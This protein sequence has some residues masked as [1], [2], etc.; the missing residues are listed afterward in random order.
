M[1]QA[2]VL[3]WGTHVGRVV[4][5]D[6]DV[7][8]VFQYTDEIRTF[9]IE[10]SPLTMPLREAPYR[11]PGLAADTF[12]RLPGLLADSLPDRF[13]NAVIDAWLRGQ[14]R[15]PGAF[16]AVERLCYTGTRGMG[17][18]EF[19]PAQGPASAGT[20][21]DLDIDALVSL[22]AS[23]L[24][25]REE[26]TATLDGKQRTDA[27]HD[28]L[29]VGTSAGGAR[30]KAIIA[31]NPDT[32]QV[33]SGQ[34]DAGGGFSYWLLKFDGVDGS[35]DRGLTDPKGFGLIE[36]AYHLMAVDAGVAMTECRLFH[37]GGR[38]H[39]MTRRFDRVASRKLHMQS[40]GGIA[41]LDYN[42]PTA[43]SYEEAFSVIGRLGLGAD[44]MEEQFRRMVFNVLARNQDDHVKNI[45]FLMDRD[46]AWSLSPAFDLTY[47]YDP[48]NRWM[49]RHQMSINGRRDDFTLAD[50][51]ATGRVARLTRGR[52]DAILSQV[53]DAVGRW[54]E[55]ATAAGVPEKRAAVV[56]AGHRPRPST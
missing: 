15:E 27:F 34:I 19:R 30:A 51:R 39:F 37:E 23:V 50:L 55:H 54:P 26:L 53:N 9:G 13:G 31:Y 18:L 6:D 28:I 14:G 40:L 41:H 3:L 46:G 16:N 8:A 32:G 25:D 24:S 48:G 42:Q 33:R 10:L 44:V 35:G 7:A 12:H 36:M 47:A 43:H 21:G 49:S 1:S 38:D 4:L 11:F 29:A 22:A 2:D 17:A 56:A 52:A 5:D 20:G 45:A